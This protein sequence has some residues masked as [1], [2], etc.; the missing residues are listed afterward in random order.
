MYLPNLPTPVPF[1]STLWIR[2]GGLT[3]QV[4]FTRHYN[5][6]IKLTRLHESRVIDVLRVS[7]S[8]LSPLEDLV[9]TTRLLRAQSTPARSR[10]TCGSKGLNI[11]HGYKLAGKWYHGYLHRAA[12]NWSRSNGTI[13]QSTPTPR[14]HLTW[15]SSWPRRK[16]GSLTHFKYRKVSNTVFKY[17]CQAFLGYNKPCFTG[18]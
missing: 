2:E 18:Q 6:K 1:N 17:M 4:N 12:L 3:D 11:W 13:K 5:N 9:F 14:I 7:L 10:C 15:S 16:T 8:N